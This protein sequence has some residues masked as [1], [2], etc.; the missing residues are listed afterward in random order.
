CTPPAAGYSCES[1]VG[2]RRRRSAPECAWASAAQAAAKRIPG[3]SGSQTTHMRPPTGRHSPPVE[4]GDTTPCHADLVPDTARPCTTSAAV[5]ATPG[6][7]S[8]SAERNRSTRHTPRPRSD[9]EGRSERHS[10]GV[11]LAWP[12]RPVHG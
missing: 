9:E 12:D 2:S 6:T 11:A 1:R 3:G 7:V 4:T 5:A 8:T 10:R